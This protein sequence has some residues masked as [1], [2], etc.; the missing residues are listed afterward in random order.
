MVTLKVSKFLEFHQDDNA[1]LEGKNVH[2][3]NVIDISLDYLT[4]DVPKAPRKVPVGTKRITAK[5]PLVGSVIRIPEDVTKCS[6]GHVY[7]KL[8]KK[9]T[10]EFLDLTKAHSKYLLLSEALAFTEWHENMTSASVFYILVAGSYSL[11][12]IS[13]FFAQLAE[14]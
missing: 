7:E 12:S 2:P 10:S 9:D 3:M 13:A 6:I 4:Q 8:V 11:I 1:Q 5:A 14:N